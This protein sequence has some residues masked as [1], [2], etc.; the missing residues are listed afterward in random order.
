MLTA[1]SRNLDLVGMVA[2]QSPVPDVRYEQSIAYNDTTASRD[3]IHLTDSYRFYVGTDMHIDS[4]Y[5]NTLTYLHAFRNDLLAPFTLMLGDMVNARDNIPWVREIFNKETGY[6]SNR[7]YATVGNHDV[8]FNQWHEW[9]EQWGSST[10][11]FVVNTPRHKDL[12]I[13]FDSANGTI[14]KKQLEWLKA[15]LDKS[16]LTEYRHKIIFTHTHIFKKDESQGH[17]SNYAME[18]T[19]YLTDLFSRYGIDLFLCGHDHSR[20]ITEF[21]GVTYITVDALEEHY[22]NAYYM[23]ATVGDDITYEFVPVGEQDE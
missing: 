5:D 1:C 10:Y 23:I 17:T 14:G 15:L 22:P 20:E 21:K 19:Y 12:Y 8:Y 6:K 4:A 11:S 13:C 18:E 9:Q 16:Q 3:I 7:V 2:G